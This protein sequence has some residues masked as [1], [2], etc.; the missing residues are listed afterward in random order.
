MIERN[1]PVVNDWRKGVWAA[2]PTGKADRDY[3]YAREWLS[4]TP[5][6]TT[7][8]LRYTLADCGGP[9]WIVVRDGRGTRSLLELGELTYLDHGEVPPVDVLAIVRAGSWDGAKCADHD[10]ALVDNR[11][12]PDC[13]TD[14]ENDERRLAYAATAPADDPF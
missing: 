2:R 8:T 4:G 13:Q 11:E 14:Q 3:V 9:G 7:G 6:K 5:D 12:C 10:R 1:Y